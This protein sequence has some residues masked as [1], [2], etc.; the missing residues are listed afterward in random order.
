ML[1][2]STVLL[3]R[4]VFSLMLVAALL[5]KAL[6]AVIPPLPLLMQSFLS[7]G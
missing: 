6:S 3:M 2:L 4:I 7:A 5:S 1:S